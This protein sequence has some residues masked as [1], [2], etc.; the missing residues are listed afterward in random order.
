MSRIGAIAGF[1]SVALFGCAQD[2]PMQAGS[3]SQTGN[4]LSG[5]LFRP[6]VTTPAAGVTARLRPIA[7]TPSDTSVLPGSVRDT[8]I[9]SLGRFRMENVPAGVYRLEFSTPESWWTSMG[10]NRS[11]DAH[12]DESAVV[13]CTVTTTTETILPDQV[14]RASANLHVTMR[15]TDTTRAAR[16][17][18]LGLDRS[19]TCTV[20]GRTCVAN[21][22]ELPAGSWT[23]RVW[24]TR[25]SRVAHWATIRLEPGTT[26][27]L[28][29]SSWSSEPPDDD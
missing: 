3:G 2:T 22:S 9:D 10:N 11:L 28:V 13:R 1:L 21:L 12:S 26:D 8:L 16:I 18:I 19:T 23:V 4:A 15:L 25:F 20:S 6:D 24:S 7:W 27:T 29:A 17:E 14:L 5:R